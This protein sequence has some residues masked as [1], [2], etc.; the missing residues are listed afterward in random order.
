MNLGPKRSWLADRPKAEYQQAK[1]LT[2]TT[3]QLRDMHPH[4]SKELTLGRESST[5]KQHHTA[6]STIGDATAM[7]HRGINLPSN[8]D[9]GAFFAT[10]I[11]QTTIPTDPEQSAIELQY[12]ARQPPLSGQLTFAHSNAVERAAIT[13]LNEYPAFAASYTIDQSAIADISSLPGFD[14]SQVLGNVMNTVNSTSSTSRPYYF[15]QADVDAGQQSNH[16]CPPLQMEMAANSEL[17][18]SYAT[19]DAVDEPDNQTRYLWHGG[20]A[21]KLTSRV[22]PCKILTYGAVFLGYLA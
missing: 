1:A 22:L 18:P 6:D 5:R 8:L 2:Q 17:V 20:K 13:S 9:E 7:E 11:S 21:N 3:N 19:Q 10:C 14:S 12:N 15:P 4:L 16:S